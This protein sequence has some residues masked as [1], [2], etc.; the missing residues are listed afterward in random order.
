M[1]CIR[2]APATQDQC[3][4]QAAKAGYITTVVC[5]AR[6]GTGRVARPDA[7]A[8]RTTPA[9]ALRPATPAEAEV[10]YQLHEAATGDYIVAIWEWDEQAQRAFHARAFNPHRWQII[11]ADQAHAGMDVE[12]RS[13]EIY[14]SR[15]EIYPDHQ[16][17]GI[18]T[19]LISALLDVLTGNRR[20]RAVPGSPG[21]RG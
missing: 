20:A 7:R 19:R 10:C 11:T 14:L 2:Q 6:N 12:Y 16:G 4:T 9:I 13:G 1:P 15:I 18:G 3:S 21:H 5:R 17:H 8:S